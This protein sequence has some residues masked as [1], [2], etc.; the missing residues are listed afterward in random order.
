M[1]AEDDS[2]DL[3]FL[4][5]LTRRE[6]SQAGQKAY[7]NATVIVY[8]SQDPALMDYCTKYWVRIDQDHAKLVD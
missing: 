1:H 5:R 8:D 3:N 6:K 4:L 7:L 2:V